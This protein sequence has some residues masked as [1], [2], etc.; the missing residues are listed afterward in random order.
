MNIIKYKRKQKRA[1]RAYHVNNLRYWLS[2]NKLVVLALF[3][4]LLATFL[5]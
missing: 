2:N 4:L 5:N 1:R 3:L